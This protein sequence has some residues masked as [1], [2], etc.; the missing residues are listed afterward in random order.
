VSPFNGWGFKRIDWV[1]EMHSRGLLD[2]EGAWALNNAL[3]GGGYV[4]GGFA[5][6]LAYGV[7]CGGNNKAAWDRI[8]WYSQIPG[9]AK[10][11]GAPWSSSAPREAVFW[12][13]NAGDID[14]FFRDP[15]GATAMISALDCRP[16][17]YGMGSSRA[18]YA[19]DYRVGSRALQ[20]ITKVHGDPEDVIGTFD[21]ANAKVVL[22]E[23]GI[24]YTMGWLQLEENRQLGIDIWNKP[25]LLWR[26]RKWARKHLYADL[27]PG[28]HAPYVE[29]VFSAMEAVNAGTLIRWGEAVKKY[30]IHSFAKMFIET[31]P[32]AEVLKISM[33]L[34]SYDQMNVIRNLTK[35]GM[36]NDQQ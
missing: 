24:H 35:L 1:G 30:S 26:V 28:D 17:I 7:L 29:A 10:Q 9:Y 34:D 21:I 19:M 6:A 23:G 4:A 3:R 20:V 36:K 13:A 15:Q 5:R 2:G 22:E 16:G 33:L 12:K 14:L 27:R 11:H 8:D 18:G 25:N 31:S 32:P